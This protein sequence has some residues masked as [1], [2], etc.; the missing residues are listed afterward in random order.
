M[1]NKDDKRPYCANCEEHVSPQVVSGSKKTG[2]TMLVDTPGPVDYVAHSSTE[3]KTLLCSNCG[4]QVF[5]V[6]FCETCNDH[7][8]AVQEY[9]RTSGFSWDQSAMEFCSECSN[10][11]SGPKKSDCFIATACYGDYDSPEVRVLRKYRDVV[12]SQSLVGNAF[13]K[14]YYHTSPPF[15]SIISNSITLKKIVRVFLA[16]IVNFCR[17]RIR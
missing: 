1:I 6:K 7:T 8:L 10:Q 16:P 14:L 2:P 11:V 3:T 12:L 13:T 5:R 17:R 9:H 15:A 4:E